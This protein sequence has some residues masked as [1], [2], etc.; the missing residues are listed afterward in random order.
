MCRRGGG[1]Q[2]SPTIENT[3]N[4]RAVRTHPSLQIIYSG[5][6]NDFLLRGSHFFTRGTSNGLLLSPECRAKSCQHSN[7]HP[8]VYVYKTY[9]RMERNGRHLVEPPSNMTCL[10]SI[11]AGGHPDRNRSSSGELG[12]PQ[13]AAQL[14]TG[15]H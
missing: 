7:N 12:P 15:H 4:R 2:G 10:L 6:P 5:I 9:R 8:K 3:G 14:I 1:E 11:L 13:E